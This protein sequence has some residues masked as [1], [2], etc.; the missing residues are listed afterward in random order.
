AGGPLAE[1]I[2][3]Y[4]SAAGVTLSFD[5]ALV[6]TLN[7]AG[8]RGRHTVQSGFN[9]L[10]AGTGLQA[11]AVTGTRY[12]LRPAL[13]ASDGA[14]AEPGRES[15]IELKGVTVVASVAPQEDPYSQLGSASVI[16]R[17]QLDRV[18]SVTPRDL[19]TSEA[20]VYIMDGN[21]DPG[22]NINIRGIQGPGRNNV[23]IDGTRQNS[24][25]YSGYAGQ[26]A[27]V[28]VDPELIGGVS[29]EKGPSSGVYGAG[30]IGGVVNLRTLGP[31]D[32]IQD[33]NAYGGRVRV[34][35][36]DSGYRMSGMA[37]GAY[38]FD[39]GLEVTAGVSRRDSDDYHTGKHDVPAG[40][41]PHCL[42]FQTPIAGC[43][44]KVPLTYQNLI[45]ALLKLDYRISDD[46][47]LAFGSTYYNNKYASWQRAFSLSDANDNP[48]EATNQTYTLK[49]TWAPAGSSW[50]DL[51]AN[52]WAVDGKTENANYF[53]VYKL[54]TSGGELFNTSR[55]H[56]SWLDFE[57]SYGG[58]YFQD[59]ARTDGQAGSSALRVGMTGAGDRNVSS[60][61]LQA[62]LLRGEWLRLDVGGRYDAYGIQAHGQYQSP[63][64]GQDPYRF[65]LDRSGG[66]FSPKASLGLTMLSGVQAYAS[67]SEGY[68]PPTLAE[69]ASS[70]TIFGAYNVPNFRLKP[71]IARNREGGFNFSKD[72]FA[73]RDAALRA[74]LAYF[75]N[76]YEDFVHRTIVPVYADAYAYTFINL[77]EATYRGLEVTLSADFGAFFVDANYTHYDKMEFCNNGV[78]SEQIV[79]VADNAQQAYLPPRSSIHGTV[80]ARLFARKLVFGL[81]VRND[82]KRGTSE[83][84]GGQWEP[85]TIYDL[86]GSYA[87]TRELSLGLSVENLRDDYY[88][89]A[90]SFSGVPSPGR[91]IKAALTYAF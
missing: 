42:D 74:K 5:A 30:T 49:Y 16:T 9:A 36:G 10:L 89:G 84:T 38:R 91:S 53:E 72:G 47:T 77:D 25:N 17:E 24:S 65:K 83:D 67:Y 70:G 19:F 46:Q 33:G 82:D 59:R 61:F 2:N 86:F 64:V 52:V 71:E 81:R 80:G 51:H 85:Y 78:C 79:N 40:G 66:R 62:S 11:I 22:L 48:Q 43:D 44:D 21:Q 69:V 15:A 90:L 6:R 12:M 8:L 35:G 54:D 58:E 31:E 68:R 76:R 32:L 41:Y 23:I 1:V 37:A 18:P 73:G 13:A 50:F 4:A 3:R 87:F 63:Y 88:I 28:Y 75:D 34:I 60:G 27:R 26:I 55:L 29:I 56:T 39:N 7:S 20:G 45:S 57:L 14:A